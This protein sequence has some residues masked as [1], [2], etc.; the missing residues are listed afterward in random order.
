MEAF[1]IVQLVG[2]SIALVVGVIVFLVV[3]FRGM[4][5]LDHWIKNRNDAGLKRPGGK[6]RKRPKRSVSSDWDSF[7]GE[8]KSITTEMRKLSPSKFPDSI[9]KHLSTEKASAELRNDPAAHVQALDSSAPPSESIA[10][11]K[12][13]TWKTSRAS[14]S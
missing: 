11:D 5:W 7:V 6:R 10:V 2:A 3:F 12:L 9:P 14:L 1:E 4:S 13:V 8:P